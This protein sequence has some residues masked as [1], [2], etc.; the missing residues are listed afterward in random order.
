MNRNI[1]FQN[2]P[3]ERNEIRILKIQRTQLP[4]AMYDLKFDSEPIGLNKK[5][6][7]TRGV[8][9]FIRTARMRVSSVSEEAMT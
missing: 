3:F 8:L 2:F 4:S 5:E 7:K 6:R 9:Y 1:Y